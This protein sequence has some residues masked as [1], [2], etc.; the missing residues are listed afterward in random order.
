MSGAIA[1]HQGNCTGF[2]TRKPHSCVIDLTV[3]DLPPDARGETMPENCCRGGLLTA[4]AIRGVQSSSSF[5][6]T[7]GNLE[8]NGSAYKP[9]NLTLMAP[10]P[11]YSC[12]PVE[13][14]DPT[15]STVID[16]KREEQVFSK[17]LL[18]CKIVIKI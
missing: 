15:V 8:G 3:V 12:S 10:G 7:V 6:V 2:T 5:D 9:V 18:R 14:T 13:D 16:G 4:R 17:Y 11:G 1:T